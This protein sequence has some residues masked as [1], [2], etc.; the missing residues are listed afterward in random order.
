MNQ[1]SGVLENFS[2]DE[3][4]MRLALEQAAYSL[5]EGNLPVG[6]VIAWKDEV[7]S[8]GR[9][10]VNS[11]KTEIAHAEFEAIYPIQQFLYKHKGECD[12]YTTLEPCFMCFGAI[13]FFSF[14]KLV[15][16]QSDNMVGAL[17]AAQN[18]QYYRTRSPF[19]QTGLLEKESQRLLAEYVDRTGRAKH[20]LKST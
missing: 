4:L 6:T 15:I 1:N 18:T 2:Q 7:M 14:R 8:I 9:N 10:Q 17:V 20:L 3:K 13:A 19:V 12:I 16:G 11:K 5:E